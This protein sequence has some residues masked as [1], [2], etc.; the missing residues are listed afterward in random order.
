MKQAS[1]VQLLIAGLL[2]SAIIMPLAYSDQRAP[3]PPPNP[4]A[5]PPHQGIE[6]D[7]SL[8]I[9]DL[10]VVEDPVRT[11]PTTDIPGVWTFRHLIEQMAGEQDPAEFA[12]RWLENWEQ[13]QVINGSRVPARPNICPL[14]IEPWLQA[15]GGQ[16][17]D[18]RK[19]PFKLLAIVSRIDLREHDQRQAK[20]AGEGRFIFGVL[21]KNGLPLP[22]AA[23]TAPGG[24]TVIFEYKLPAETMD[25]LRYWAEDWSDLSRFTPGSQGYNAAL[26]ALTRRFTDKNMAPDKP[27]GSALAQIRTNEVA[28]GLPWELREFVIDF[29]TGRL[30]LQPVALTPDT[31]ALNGTETLAALINAN[32]RRLLNDTF[33]L[34]PQWFG[35]VSAAGPFQLVEFP[36]VDNRSFT[37]TPLIGPFNNIPWSAAGIINNDARHLFALNTCSGCHRDETGTGFLHVGFPE[38][39]ALP[40]SLGEPAALSGFLTGTEVLDPVDGVT[41]RKFADL[42]RR[43]QD[44]ESLLASFAQDPAGP[45]DRH[46]PTFVH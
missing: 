40:N 23:G 7:R 14:V 25:E 19:A 26:E 5:E 31:Y 15:S 28:L 38:Q 39:H 16:R 42:E 46:K 11:D 43:R 36:D 45:N 17:L 37:V 4:A 44:L 34:D 20:N 3:A 29:A 8:L 18:L 22:P 10:G 32:E 1:T 27:N 13:K 24:F 41:P 9:T 30:R 21:D 35:S 2:A 12:L 6:I 33:E